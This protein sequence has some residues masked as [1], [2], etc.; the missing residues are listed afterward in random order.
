MSRPVLALHG[1][2]GTISRATI[3]PAEEKEYRE[4]LRRPLQAGWDLLASGS[5]ALEVAC[6]VVQMLEDDPLFNAGRGSVYTHDGRHEMDAAVM[7]GADRAAGGVAGV[8]GVRNPIRLAELVLCKSDHVLL[9]A[10]GAQEFAREQGVV[11]ESSEYFHTDLRFTQLQ[12]ARDAGRVQLDHTAEKERDEKFGTVGAVVC[13]SMGNLAAATSTGGMTNKKYGRIGDSPIIG[14]GTW[15]DNRTCAVSC[16]GYGE[17]FM[18]AVAAYDLAA[19]MEYRRLGLLEAATYLTEEK[20]RA[21]GA[22]GGLVAVD[23]KGNV[24]LPF[25]SEGMYR[26]YARDGKVTVSIFGD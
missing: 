25:N 11:F 8:S 1:G 4:A 12:R 19:L 7:R 17:Y 13:D 22:E 5:D 24:A 15:A 2:A 18:R 16:T 26:G 9:A 23:A 3:T 10:E 6:V 14:A 20:L 21:F